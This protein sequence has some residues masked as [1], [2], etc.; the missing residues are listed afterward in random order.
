MCSELTN[1]TLLLAVSEIKSQIA[2]EYFPN[3]RQLVEICK[4]HFINLI[5]VKNEPHRIHDILE[6]A[7]NL[8]LFEKYAN[9]INENKHETLA[10]LENLAQK[11]PTQNWR[12]IEQT[13]YQQFSTPPALAFLI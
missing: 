8:Y 13:I 6:T 4:K 11:L 2:T 7:V 12:D 1:Q 9:S 10:E 5:D 3:N